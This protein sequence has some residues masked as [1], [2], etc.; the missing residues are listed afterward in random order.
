MPDKS[1]WACPPG[2]GP[3]GHRQPLRRYPVSLPHK[4]KGSF[5]GVSLSARMSQTGRSATS[6]ADRRF[7]LHLSLF[8]HFMSIID[9]N[10]EIPYCTLQLGMA[11]KQ[12]NCTQIFCAAVYQR[13]FC[14]SERVGAVACSIQS[15]LMDPRIDDPSI[16]R[17]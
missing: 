9:L 3:I 13:R 17:R 15:Q 12:L 1:L 10:A 6:A 5:I 4:A 7:R 8:R 11:Q 16:L 14:P 2:H